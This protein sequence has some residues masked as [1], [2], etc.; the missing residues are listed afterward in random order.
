MYRDTIAKSGDKA[1][2]Q[3]NIVKQ[4]KQVR[5]YKMSTSVSR[6]TH[7]INY[8]LILALINVM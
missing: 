2:Q 1:T 3:A 4:Y 6:R 8:F 7:T 5:W